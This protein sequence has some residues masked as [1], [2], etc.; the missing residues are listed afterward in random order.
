[1]DKD[2]I[3]E[4]EPNFHQKIKAIKDFVSDGCTMSPD[5][6]FSFC[7]VL[8]DIYYSYGFVT[9]RQA[10]KELRQCIKAKG[11]KYL[12]WIYWFFV[13]MLGWIPYYFLKPSKIRKKY[14]KDKK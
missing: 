4:K 6:S 5:L 8:H 14:K 2:E 12:A 11:H 13:R 9:R 3:K 1:M 10:D 7:C